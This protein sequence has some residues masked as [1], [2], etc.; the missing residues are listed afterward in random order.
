MIRTAQ[1]TPTEEESVVDVEGKATLI[2]ANGDQLEASI[3]GTLNPQT[4][5]AVLAYEWKRGTGRFQNASG[6]ATWL[7]DLHLS[8]HTY[9][10]VADGIIDY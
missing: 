3:K 7:V 2:A 5:H 6:V 9:D 1:L 4:N 10:V 8:D